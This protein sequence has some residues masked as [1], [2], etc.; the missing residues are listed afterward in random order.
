[1]TWPFFRISP[2]GFQFRFPEN[3][4]QIFFM[5]YWSKSLF[6]FSASAASN[7]PEVSGWMKEYE[8]QWCKRLFMN[9]EA[10]LACSLAPSL[11]HAHMHSHPCTFTRTHARI[12]T[13][14]HSL[15][16]SHTRSLSL[17]YRRSFV[18]WYNN[19][20]LLHV[21]LLSRKENVYEKRKLIFLVEEGEKE[22]KGFQRCSFKIYSS[23]F[24]RSKS[25]DLKREIKS[26]FI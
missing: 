8:S 15:S 1:M 14:S 19:R 21:W 7:S 25:L 4:E 23:N 26:L 10:T 17:Q 11:S 18:R 16:H 6:S 3:I 22:R 20:L 12:R 13:L 5:K 2:W 9:I 24:F